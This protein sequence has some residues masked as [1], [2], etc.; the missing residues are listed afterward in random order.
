MLPPLAEIR[1][2][3]QRFAEKPAQLVE[4][5]HEGTRRARATA[6]ATMAEVRAAV[7]LV[8]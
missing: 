6:S 5:L 7:N 1:E 4:I 8:P 2:R 3:R